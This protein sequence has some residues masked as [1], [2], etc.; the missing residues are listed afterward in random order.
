MLI[1]DALFDLINENL[2]GARKPNVPNPE[3]GVV[4]AAVTTAQAR[5]RG[6]PQVS[7]CEENDVENGCR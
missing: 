2:Q 1:K 5:D 7:K 4:T 6:D 3:S